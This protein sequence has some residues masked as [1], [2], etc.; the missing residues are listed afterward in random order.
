MR[1]WL[2]AARKVLP[3]HF[4]EVE[5]WAF[6][7]ELDEVW[8]KWRKIIPVTPFWAIQSIF[9]EQFVRRMIAAKSQE[10]LAET[11]VQCTGAHLIKADIRYIQFWN[12]AY[13]EAAKERPVTLKLPFKD[14]VLGGY[15]RL[16]ERRSLLS[17]CSGEWWCVSRGIA[18]PI[19]RD[20]LEPLIIR[21]LPN[22]YNPIR[23]NHEKRVCWRDEMRKFYGFS[24]S[25]IVFAFSAFGHFERK[26]L[27]QAA[28]AIEILRNEGHAVCMLVLGGSEDAIS[29]FKKQMK[30]SNIEIQGFVFAGLISDIE[31]HLSAADAFFMPSHFEAF[32][33]AEIEAAAL[34]LRLYLTAHP[35]H[36][37]IL[38]EGVNGRL[39]PWEPEGMARIIAEE[40]R[41]G[42]VRK[43][44]QEMGEALIAES[45]AMT[46]ATH[47]EAAI[48]RKW[49]I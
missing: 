45:Y 39:L 22:A 30:V 33:L 44:H 11:L 6:D 36:E 34:G 10:Y 8:V 15:H 40:I 20:S 27:R 47:Y 17:G 41:N 46:M 24:E 19:I 21:Y 49:G 31:N 35:G 37:M 9:Y 23:F 32:S 38:R 3:K 16:M 28:Q 14:R 48:A 2:A 7:C 42:D 12:I 25:A 29:S 43:I 4:D 18:S 26:G 13:A 1:G 5:I